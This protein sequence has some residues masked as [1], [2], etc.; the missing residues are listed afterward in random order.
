MAG[1]PKTQRIFHSIWL[2]RII[3]ISSLA[4]SLVV[5]LIAYKA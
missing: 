2:T 1:F 3:A 5:C 4:M